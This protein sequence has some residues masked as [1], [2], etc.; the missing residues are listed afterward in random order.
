VEARIR[1]QTERFDYGPLARRV[2]PETD[3]EGWI[4]LDLDIAGTAP[5]TRAL[6]AHANGTLDFLAAP[7]NIDTDAFDLWAVSLLRFIV[8]RLDPGPRSTLNC[9]VARFDLADG[10]M[11][12]KALLLDT[13]EMVVHGDARV[14]FRKERFRAALTPEPKEAEVLSLQTRVDVSGGFEDFRIGVA[15]EEFLVTLVRFASSIVV[16]PLR[17]IFEEPLPADGE[18]TCLA[19]WQEDRD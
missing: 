17:R 18:E 3:M 13:T 8:P 14:D 7:E 15:P 12:E 1:A 5:G 6:L 2:D 16:A 9:L 19:A 11:D 10:I 4:S